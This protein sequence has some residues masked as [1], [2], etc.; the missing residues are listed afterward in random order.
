MLAYDLFQSKEA[1]EMG[2]KYVD[3]VEELLPKCQIVTLHCPLM[4]D[5]YHLMNDEKF[6]LMKR[7]SMLVNTSRGGLVDTAALGRALDTQKIACVG[8][9][10]Y[11][12]EAGLFFEDKSEE[13]DATPGSS[14]SP[15]WDLGLSA[16]ASRP[17]VLV[18][19]H[20]AFL[21][22]EALGN[23]ASTTVDNLM[24]FAGGGVGARGVSTS[25]KWSATDRYEGTLKVKV[26]G[27]EPSFRDNRTNSTRHSSPARV[28]R[29]RRSRWLWRVFPPA[30]SAHALLGYPRARPLGPRSSSAEPRAHAWTQLAS[31]SSSGDRDRI[32]CGTRTFA[33]ASDA[34]AAP[35]AAADP[36]PR[37]AGP[38]GR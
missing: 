24:E 31:S 23:I 12:H 9:D 32:R 38:E 25:T 34:T 35:D 15:D 1:I 16:L 36:D 33:A 18:T 29:W 2:V 37:E 4:D 21:T 27:C 14:L 7:G 20:Q 28:S 19:S 3:T 10:V 6:N 17:N 8:M 22:A 13:T 5:T 26:I 30:L 11:E